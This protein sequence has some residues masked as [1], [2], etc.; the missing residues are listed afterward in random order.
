MF[1]TAEN[2]SYFLY[3]VVH[4]RI[5]SLM[6]QG[7]INYSIKIAHYSCPT[8]TT[9]TTTVDQLQQQAQAVQQAV[10]SAPS[11]QR[12]QNFSFEGFP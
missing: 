1:A 8:S 12:V 5:N 7:I 6:I 4:Y 3:S 11:F 10:Q 9:T 2:F